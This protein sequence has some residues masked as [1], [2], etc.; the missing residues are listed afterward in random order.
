[1]VT[2]TVLCTFDRDPSIAGS[3]F[4]LLLTPD[5]AA[6]SY[7]KVTTT[8]PGQFYYNVFYDHAP[9]TVTL[10][11]QIPFPFIT[12]GARPIH[13][14]SS[15]EFTTV[16]G[17]TCL[18]PGDEIYSSNQQ[19]KLINYNVQ[20]F[21]GFATVEVTFDNPGTFSYV[22][23]HLEYGLKAIGG[24]FK[25]NGAPTCPGSTGNDA[26][27]M[28]SPFWKICDKADYSFS[29]S[30]VG[31]LGPWLDTQTV[32]NMNAFK[33]DPGF[34]GFVID[35]I[36]L[37]GV[38]GVKVEIY[39]PKGSLIGTVYTDEDGYY[40]F[41]WKHTGKA[42]FYKVMLPEHGQSMLV[43]MKPNTFVYVNFKI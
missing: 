7:Y 13:A 20:D 31:V 34:A 5:P 4:R 43:L 8:N 12:Q 30:E 38:Q 42:A 28:F 29:V 37:N 33:H 22:N 1:M 2:D 23:I 11:L 14:Y 15:V 24:W 10:Y 39:N 41:S 21:G 40:M 9:G 25:G 32:Q 17:K 27:H 16:D 26:I 19:I 6:P 3:Q 18:M 36:S 35:K